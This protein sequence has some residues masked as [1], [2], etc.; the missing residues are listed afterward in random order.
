M[1]QGR[2]RGGSVDGTREL[3]VDALEPRR[4]LAG[5]AGIGFD[6][7]SSTVDAYIIEG[8]A[9]PSGLASGQVFVSGASGRSTGTPLAREWV[10]QRDL[11]SLFLRPSLGAEGRDIEL[12]ANFWSSRGYPAGWHAGVDSTPGA[13]Q[14][15]YMIERPASATVAALEGNWIW[16]VFQWNPSTGAAT[17]LNGTLSVSGNF[18]LWFATGIGTAPIARTTEIT[19]VGSAGLF[20]TS[21]GESVYISADG[22]VMLTADMR[23]SDGDLFIGVAVKADTTV[24][25]AEVAGGY[26]FGVGAASEAAKQLFGTGATGIGAQYLDLRGDGTATVY[27]LADYDAGDLSHGIAATWT[28]SGSTLRLRLTGSPAQVEFAVSQNGST[29]TPF[30]MISQQGVGSRVAGIATRATPV[31]AVTD[32]TLGS[33]AILQ[34]GTGKPLVYILRTDGVWRQVDLIAAAGGSDPQTQPGTGIISYTDPKDGKLYVATTTSDGVYLYTRAASGAWTVRN[35]TEE[36]DGSQVIL[37]GL[38]QF[39][40]TDAARLVTIAGLAADGDLLMYRQTGAVVGGNYTYAFNDVADEFLRPLGKEMPTFVGP[41]VAY[42]TPWN[43][44]NI[45][46]LNASG[47]IEV[48]WNSAKTGGYWVLSNLSNITAAPPFS[49]GLTVYQTAWSGINIVGINGSGQIVTT[50]WIPRFAGFWATSNLT[51]IVSGPTL[52]GESIVAFPTPNGGLNIAGIKD[53]GEIA[54]YWWV[55]NTDNTWR[56]REL[57][58]GEPAQIERPEG[59]LRAQVLQDGSIN[60]FGRG[61]SDDLIRIF[62]EPLLQVDDWRLQNVSDLAI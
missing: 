38:T 28:L 18:M 56:V 7:V 53:D 31:T 14:L 2:R 44:Q 49:G 33:D 51:T 46:G 17:V 9:T 10:E 47:Q 50:W 48:I 3:W 24:T 5:F 54:L 23:E 20:E 22:S 1:E 37:S 6:R 25:V 12:G 21:R 4:L 32:L 8:T 41:L 11:G 58:E 13:G 19:S 26:R 43:G 29:L 57:T 16:T 27:G 34:V 60:I 55:P 52:Q 36:I 45:A 61:A 35:L 42:V 62:W 39:V 30:A 59:A 40:S 15:S